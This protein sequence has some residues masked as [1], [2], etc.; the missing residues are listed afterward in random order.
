MNE[1]KIR[2]LYDSVMKEVKKYDYQT[3]M[4][5]LG[6]IHNELVLLATND[7]EK[8][9][10]LYDMMANAAAI[11]GEHGSYKFQTKENAPQV[12]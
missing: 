5:T 9:K 11:L 12:H 2:E 8:I 10:E 6:A 3:Q 4:I 7:P 1:K